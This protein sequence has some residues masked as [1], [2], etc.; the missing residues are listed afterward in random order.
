MTMWSTVK[1]LNYL[2]TVDIILG[3]RKHRVQAWRDPARRFT[4]SPAWRLELNQSHEL[5][6]CE[7]LLHQHDNFPFL[8]KLSQEVW[9][10][11][12]WTE[13]GLQLS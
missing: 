10:P 1:S 4:N 8:L 11:A 3:L 13:F 9:P 7:G 5:E 12:V 2:V 6:F